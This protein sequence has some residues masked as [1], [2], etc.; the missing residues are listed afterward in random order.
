MFDSPFSLKPRVRPRVSL[1]SPMVSTV[2]EAV[3]LLEERSSALVVSARGTASPA[4]EATRPGV[5]VPCARALEEALELAEA[6]G[7]SIGGR[8]GTLGPL[9]SSRCGTELRR[10]RTC[11]LRTGPC[12]SRSALRGA[13]GDRV[14]VLLELLPGVGEVG[15]LVGLLLEHLHVVALRGRTSPRRGQTPSRASPMSRM[16]EVAHRGAHVVEVVDLARRNAC[17]VDPPV[18]A[19]SSPWPARAGSARTASSARASCESRL[20]RR[21]VERARRCVPLQ[22][23]PDLLLERRRCAAAL[24]VLERRVLR[25]ER[26]VRVL[27]VV[28]PE[29]VVLGKGGQTRSPAA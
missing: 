20:E 27:L 6:L 29:E 14:G 9:A 23:V 22:D 11:A 3:E 8:P 13:R 2:V 1:N 7:A 12:G 28:L 25:H 15:H 19:S 16:A 5:R 4:A 18:I 21:R 10:R 26:L 24:Q 17:R